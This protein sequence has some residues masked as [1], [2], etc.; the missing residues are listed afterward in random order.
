MDTSRPASLYLRRLEIYASH[1]AEALLTGSYRSVFKGQGIE[2]EEVRPYNPGDDIRA[3][4]WNVTARLQ[5][6]YVKNFRE[7]RQLPMLLL[8]DLS[9]ST[10]M[11][12]SHSSKR[13]RFAEAAALL[14]FAAIKNRDHVGAIFFSQQ[15][16]KFL[17]PE[18]TLRQVDRIVYHILQADPIE[19]KANLS[20]A[21]HFLNHVQKRRTICFLLTDLFL[22]LPKSELMK[23]A[24]HHELIYLNV[25]S[26]FESDFPSAALCHFHDL[27]S[28]KT[29]WV[30]TDSNKRSE[31]LKQNWSER[32]QL[33]KEEL[34]LLGIDRLT[35]STEEPSYTALQRFFLQRSR[36]GR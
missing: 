35:L 19:S 17:P 5:Q 13:D 1:L 22:D 29:C 31:T 26:P 34:K 20:L 32:H 2:F 7:E 4:D 14:A 28:G 24:K 27:E 36:R 3:I 30:D 16:E 9:G 6:P 18:G 21:L 12:G 11:Q 8:V 10:L 15:I 33:V 25:Q 23:T